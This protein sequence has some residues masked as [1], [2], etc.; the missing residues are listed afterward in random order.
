MRE[1]FFSLEAAHEN[2]KHMEN[3]WV[4]EVQLVVG[5]TFDRMMQ[6]IVGENFLQRITIVHLQRWF[7]DALFAEHCLSRGHSHHKYTA[8]SLP[9]KSATQQKRQQA[10]CNKQT[11]EE[12]AEASAMRVRQIDWVEQAHSAIEAAKKRAT[13]Q[14]KARSKSEEER[15]EQDKGIFVQYWVMDQMAQAADAQ[16][17][18]WADA[19]A[20]ARPPRLLLPARHS[21]ALGRRAGAARAA[22]GWRSAG[23]YRSAHCPLGARRRRWRKESRP[24]LQAG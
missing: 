12:L 6:M 13:A 22:A 17:L 8:Q 7:D 24:A 14:L 1:S 5:A 9:V 2:F 16:A 23:R 11:A 20:R 21:R 19:Q 15:R 3:L 10:R 4:H 18:Y